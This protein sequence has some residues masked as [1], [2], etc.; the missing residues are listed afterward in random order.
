MSVLQVTVVFMNVF[1]YNYMFRFV[2]VSLVRFKM[3]DHYGSHWP[4]PKSRWGM[5]VGRR[6]QGGA[7]RAGIW[8]PL[9][10]QIVPLNIC[11][12]R[13]PWLDD[14]KDDMAVSD[15][16]LRTTYK[17]DDTTEMAT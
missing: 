7:G 16:V 9:K 8:P 13:R 4:G 14:M 12:G 2:L 15:S 11:C 5:Q 3:M 6:R 17:Y 1:C 10:S